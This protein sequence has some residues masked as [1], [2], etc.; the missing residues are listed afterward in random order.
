MT[1]QINVL[2]TDNTAETNTSVLSHLYRSHKTELP[3]AGVDP[4]VA[5]DALENNRLPLATAQAACTLIPVG[6]VKLEGL[7]HKQRSGSSQSTGLKNLNAPRPYV[8]QTN[9]T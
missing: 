3:R 7:Q 1:Y 6:G 5:I 8:T 4:T 9:G 2:A